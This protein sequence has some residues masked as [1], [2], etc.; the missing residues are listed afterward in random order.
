MR[1]EEKYF[2]FYSLMDNVYF[3]R[4][5]VMD[6]LHVLDLSEVGVLGSEQEGACFIQLGFHPQGLVVKQ[7]ELRL[8][9]FVLHSLLHN[10]FWNI[11]QIHLK[12]QTMTVKHWK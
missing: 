1:S 7:G 9:T 8:Q 10:V 4:S 6:H 3:K 12:N 2:H 5:T 11:P